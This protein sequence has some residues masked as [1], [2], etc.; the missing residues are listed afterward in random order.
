[1]KSHRANDPQLYE[2]MNHHKEF[3]ND[4]KMKLFKK[5]INDDNKDYLNIISLDSYLKIFKW[6]F[7]FFNATG[8][9][10]GP[11]LVYLFLKSNLFEAIF[12]QAIL[13]L[14]IFNI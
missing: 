4:F 10:V 9:Q 2:I 1:M 6:E 3:I 7:F 13:P 5:Y 14:T 11:A 8:F 12:T